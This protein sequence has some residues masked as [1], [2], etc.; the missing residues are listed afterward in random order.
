MLHYCHYWRIYLYINKLCCT[1]TNKRVPE[2]DICYDLDK[3]EN[4]ELHVAKLINEEFKKEKVDIISEKP[5]V[6]ALE[7]FVDKEENDALS[8]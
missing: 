5:L 2:E 8:E 1:V 3:I 6:D 7:L 4:A